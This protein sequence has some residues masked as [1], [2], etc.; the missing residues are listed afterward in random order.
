MPLL[1]A[2]LV[3]YYGTDAKLR[4]FRFER[5]IP[6]KWMELHQLYLRATELGV[7]RVAVALGE[8]RAATRR[9][10]RSSRNTCSCC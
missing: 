6:A 4:V 8:R 9:S 1:F 10:G 2:R 3:H 7:E 5:W